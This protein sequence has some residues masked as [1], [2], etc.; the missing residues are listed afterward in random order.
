MTNK[1]T[2]GLWRFVPEFGK[3]YA[4]LRENKWFGRVRG[5]ENARLIAAAPEMLEALVLCRPYMY[6]HASNTAD[7]AFD[8]LCAA[9]NKA[10]EETK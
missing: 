8:K 6:E 2:P 4:L 9:I 5:K 1:H 10:V 3:H 7:N